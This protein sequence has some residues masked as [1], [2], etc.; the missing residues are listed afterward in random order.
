MSTQL[1]DR[2]SIEKI[3]REMTLEEKATLVTGGG[4]FRSAEMKKYGIP[5]A[6]L[7]DGATGFNTMQGNMDI[8]F[9]EAQR[10]AASEGNALDPESFG[11]MGGTGLG[12]AT[13]SKM[14]KAGP[15]SDK[16]EKAMTDSPESAGAYGCYPP[17]MFLAST[18]DP[19]TARRC[20]SALAK[21]M[22]SYG[23]DV[24]L[25]PN[26]NIQRDPRAGRA[27]EGYS[28]DPML[29][30]E[31][32]SALIRGIQGEGL[33]ACAK[34]FA[35]NSQET[36][37][38]H[39]EEHISERALRE[40]YFPAFRKCVAEGCFAVMSSYNKINGKESA[41]NA[42][43]LREVLREEWGFEGFVVSDWGASY[44][45]V[46]AAAAGNDLTMPGPRGI[47]CII[48][49]VQEG[50]L[51]E[52]RLDDCIRHFLQTLLKLP[53][54][55]GKRQV[56][57]M[58]ETMAANERAAREGIVLLKNNGVLPLQKDVKIS[59][60]GERSRQQFAGSGSGSAEVETSLLTN[61]YDSTVAVVGAERVAYETEAP[62]TKVWIVCA[63]A[64]GQE[65][66]D[67]PD[68]D[69]DAEGKQALETALEKAKAQGGKV[70]LVINSAGAVS[71]SAYAERLDAILFAG[72][73]GM[74]GGKVIADILFGAVNPSGKLP[75]TWP[76][77][78]RDMPSYLN[79]P[80]ENGEVW[81]G[82]GIYVGY[83]YF[84]SKGIRPRYA[85]GHGLSYTSFEVTGAQILTQPS[86]A[87]EGSCQAAYPEAPEGIGSSLAAVAAADAQTTPAVDGVNV[88][89]HDLLLAV[90]VKNTGR[91]D[92]SEVVQVYVHDVVSHIRKPEQEL[93]GFRKMFI[94]AG[95]EREVRIPLTKRDLASYSEEKKSWVTEPGDFEL[96]IGFASDDIRV[97]MPIAVRC[98][99]P[100]AFSEKTSLGDIAASDAAVQMIQ[101]VTGIQLLKQA[102]SLIVFLPGT[103]WKSAW[104]NTM[105]PAMAKKGMAEEEIRE[106]YEIILEKFLRL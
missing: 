13:W 51:E 94:P 36:D 58:E 41:M 44:D 21:E 16:N 63:G 89:T 7:L 18:W 75:V 67:R 29:A 78:L 40:I 59:F 33:A 47:R 17:G 93:K 50:R 1:K 86:A 102:K 60:Y 31:M 71:L 48:D 26:V 34:H 45:Q 105:A 37:R 62:G 49:A 97:C 65:G 6:L 81:Y 12:M 39:L 87:S 30:G 103:K 38:M 20:G 15:E 43:L 11:D 72:Y 8:G 96:R 55:I 104:K 53:V 73:P 28:E 56:F 23:V 19:E 9:R 69:M 77:E 100:F 10:R 61:P 106:K 42:W 74:M 80:G 85:F 98:E 32:A 64:N 84:D 2:E 83:R 101:Q 3:I 66:S 95:E 99:N 22:G 35:A 24:I 68:M 79:F 52:A 46:E 82:E 4:P 91:M 90:K 25:G 5:A 57:S 70:I 92:G 27:F 54:M 76:M 14:Q 88:D